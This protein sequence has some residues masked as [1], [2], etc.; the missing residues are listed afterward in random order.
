MISTGM[1]FQFNSDQ[2]MGLIMLSDGET[3]EFG[4]H[5]WIDTKN[6]PAIGQ[7]ISYE[8]NYGR[9]QIQVLNEESPSVSPSSEDES[10]VHEE[11]AGD[12]GVEQFK[13]V[14][15]F[16]NYYTD[17]GFKLVSD[18]V[19]GQSRIVNFRLYTP[20]DYGEATIKQIGAEISV[21]Q[22]VNGK[23]ELLS[24]GS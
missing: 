1:I 7:K 16:I 9:I 22:V 20:T 8:D 24:V 11:D 14:D 15:D 12:T 10:I 18:T 17:N 19:D 13:N 2:G 23:K 21:V 3:K 6:M 5:S 4:T